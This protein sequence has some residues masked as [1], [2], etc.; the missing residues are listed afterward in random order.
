MDSLIFV[1]V[2]AGLAI[3]AYK[4]VPSVQAKVDSV[5]SYFKSTKTDENTPSE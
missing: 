5:F 1:V 3:A 4:F 2:V